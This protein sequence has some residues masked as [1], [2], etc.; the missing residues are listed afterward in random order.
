MS[1]RWRQLL[2]SFLASSVLLVACKKEYS[3]DETLPVSYSPSVII[4]SNNQVVFALNPTSGQKSWEIGL[5]C[6]VLASPIIYNGSVYIASSNRDT[7]YKINSKTGKITRKVTYSGSGAGAK[8]TPIADGKI[9]YVA[10]TNGRLFAIDTSDYSTKWSFAADG[11]L[12]A[13]PTIHNGNIYF[14]SKVGTV[15]CLEKTNGTTAPLPASPTATWSL[16]IPGASFVSSPAVAA[17]YLFLGSLSDS[18]MYCIYLDAPVGGTTGI[19]RWS[20]KTKGGIKSSPAAYK[21]TCIFGANDFRLYCL[22]TTIDPLFGIT[23]PEVRW[24]DSLNSEVVSSPFPYDQTVY[25][26]CKDYRVYALRMINGS[27]KWTF[28][29][30]GVITSSPLAYNGTVYVGSFDKYLYALDTARGT[31]KWKANIN[32][33]IECSPVIDDLTKLTGHNSQI[34]GYTN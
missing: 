13:S 18:N 32:G 23:V 17:P 27:A 10:S 20:Y 21:G 16:T 11:P 8:A 33:Q 4:S 2:L 19:M 31:L 24:I 3:P 14:A 1:Q 26:G 29:S 6:P 12:E 30:N 22:D 5:P 34:S 25:V 15:Y 7:L 28:S 9:I